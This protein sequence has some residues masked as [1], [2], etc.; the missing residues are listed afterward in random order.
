MKTPAT[1]QA[2]RVMYAAL[3]R[4]LK[5]LATFIFI[6]HHLRHFSFYKRASS[7]L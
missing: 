3:P 6:E 4:G 7:P 2:V 1:E 5:L